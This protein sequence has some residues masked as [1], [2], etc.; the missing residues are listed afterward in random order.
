MRRRDFTSW[1][2]G[3]LSGAVLASAGPIREAHAKSKAEGNG[4]SVEMKAGGPYAAGKEGA[5]TVSIV[6]TGEFKIN[7]QF[8]FKVKLGDPPEGVTYPKRVV[9]KEDG[10]FDEKKGT[11]K[12][13]FVAQRAGKFV[14]S[15]TVSLS[16]CND[17][18]CL[19]QKVPLDVEVTVQ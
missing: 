3:G 11:L 9:K 12:V 6:A 10:T 18:K 17:K 7:Q 16:V 1:A 15:A 13:P 8:P 2:V 5:A 14:I 19:M 4:F